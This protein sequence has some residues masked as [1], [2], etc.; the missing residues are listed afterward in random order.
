MANYLKEIEVSRKIK[1]FFID[2][3]QVIAFAQGNLLYILNG[4]DLQIITVS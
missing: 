1:F 2:F 4:K 3:N